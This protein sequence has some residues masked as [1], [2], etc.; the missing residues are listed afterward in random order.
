MLLASCGG[1]AREGFY[2]SVNCL[3]WCRN[4]QISGNKGSGS[5]DNFRE[6][7]GSFDNLREFSGSFDTF[8]EFLRNLRESTG[9]SIFVSK[10]CNTST[11]PYPHPLPPQALKTLKLT[12]TGS[13]ESSLLPDYIPGKY[14]GRQKKSVG[15][16]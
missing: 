4:M 1:V 6:F 8:R 13:L 3:P 9:C 11:C 7:S 5:F 16:I 12:W 10:S 15:M 14:T 2:P